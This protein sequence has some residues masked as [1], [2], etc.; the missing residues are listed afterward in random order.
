M[1]GALMM[2]KAQREEM[3]YTHPWDVHEV[4]YIDDEGTW[5]WAKR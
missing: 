5:E 4:A 3:K 1:V 2:L